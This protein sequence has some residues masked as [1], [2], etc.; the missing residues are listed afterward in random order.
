V[1]ELI[2]VTD[3]GIGLEAALKRHWVASGAATVRVL[4]ALYLCGPKVWDS[5]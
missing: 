2:A 3:G 4:R 5:F 1:R